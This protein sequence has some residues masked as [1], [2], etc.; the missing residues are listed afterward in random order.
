MG[1]GVGQGAKSQRA[2]GGNEG[3]EGASPIPT[4]TMHLMKCGKSDVGDVVEGGNLR[5][6]GEDPQVISARSSGGVLVK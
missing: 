3:G 2:F 6:G 4:Q 5:V 1:R